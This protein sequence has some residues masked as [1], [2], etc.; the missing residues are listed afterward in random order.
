MANFSK[1]NQQISHLQ[2]A[3]IKLKIKC[4]NFYSKLPQP[5]FNRS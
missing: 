3:P 1:K 5:Y 2:T 4:H